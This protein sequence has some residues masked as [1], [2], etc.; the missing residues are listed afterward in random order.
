M[1]LFRREIKR[2]FTG[3]IIWIISL[4]FLIFITM[5][6]FPS[7]AKN[8]S[9]MQQIINQ[10]PKSIIK[11]FNMDKVSFTSILGYYSSQI[12]IL[13]VL[14]VSI[15]AMLMGAGAISK[16]LDE[17]TIEFLQSK[18]VTR[19]SVLTQKL[20]YVLTYI[21]SINVVLF[22]ITFL[23]FEIFKSGSYS[24]NILLLI[25]VGFFLIEISFASIGVLISL[26][27]KKKNAATPLS[28]WFVIGMYFIYTLSGI[29]D[30]LKF[31]KY[32]TLFKYA[33]S[34]DIITDSSLNLIYV[35]VLLLVCTIS[36]ALSYAVYRKKDL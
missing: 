24:V 17:Q 36:I 7:M 8:G 9:S 14:S 3:F 6:M 31:L 1:L 18:P 35:L 16:E 28:L 22:L 19:T 26:F 30:K 11:A 27:M 13:L 34:V 10:M 25:H 12:G 21:A 33:D 29:S 4:M 2:N 15:Y 20:L 5:S 32:A 23:S